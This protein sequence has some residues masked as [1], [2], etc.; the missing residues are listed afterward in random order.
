VARSI[1]NYLPLEHTGPME[2]SIN[3]M[4][5]R[6]K[7]ETDPSGTAATFFMHRMSHNTVLF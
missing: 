7:T 3:H 5:S 6:W 1:I 4:K 2:V